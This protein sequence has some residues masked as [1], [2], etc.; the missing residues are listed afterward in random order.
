MKSLFFIFDL[1]PT[2]ENQK[3]VPILVRIIFINLLVFDFILFISRILHTC[4]SVLFK[5]LSAWMLH[6]MLLD[7]YNEFFIS[8]Q[9]PKIESEDN[10][11]REV[12]QQT[13][14]QSTVIIRGITGKEL[15]KMRV[16]FAITKSVNFSHKMPITLTINGEIAMNL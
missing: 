16:C 9:P 5:Q 15:D 6:G 10:N 3:S 13:L 12:E 14:A 8:N 1:E 11:A 2:W 4:H 7:D